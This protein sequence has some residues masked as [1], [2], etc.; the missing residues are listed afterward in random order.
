ML[1]KLDRFPSHLPATLPSI[2]YLP[3][4]CSYDEGCVMV[5][6]GR[7]EP[8]ASMDASGKIIWARHNEVQTVNVKALGDAEEVSGAVWCVCV[9]VCVC[10]FV[11]AESGDRF[12]G[13]ESCLHG[14]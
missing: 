7:E 5:K 4:A 13:L 11:G 9:C 6:L 14:F 2:P 8:V 10:I 12:L 1:L 3:P